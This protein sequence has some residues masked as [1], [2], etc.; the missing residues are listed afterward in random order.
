M[1]FR[2]A[3]AVLFDPNQAMR[4]LLRLV[5]HELLLISPSLF[6]SLTAHVLATHS[7]VRDVVAVRA[8]AEIASGAGNSLGLA[9]DINDETG[10]AVCIGAGAEVVDFL[11]GVSHHRGFVIGIRDWGQNL[12]VGLLQMAI[13]IHSG[14]TQSR[15]SKRALEAEVVREA[16]FARMAGQSEQASAF[17][18]I[19]AVPFPFLDVFLEFPVKL[20]KFFFRA[21]GCRHA[22]RTRPRD[23]VGSRQCI[24]RPLKLL[25]IISSM[26]IPNM[27]G[28]VSF[29]FGRSAKTARMGSS[30]FLHCSSISS[31]L[32]DLVFWT[33]LS[34]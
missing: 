27:S 9:I 32:P 12:E 34:T 2:S 20:Q 13:A 10:G 21:I 33:S 16:V 30:K 18:S 5:C 6:V 17:A 11:Q 28:I 1:L 4:A 7:L 14:A 26:V 25:C 22:N 24:L 23:A 15:L 31:S 19:I 3:A 8:K 29:F